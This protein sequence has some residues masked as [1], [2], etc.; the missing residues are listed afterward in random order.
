VHEGVVWR[1]VKR[2]R[3]RPSKV[4]EVDVLID[5][6]SVTGAGVLSPADTFV[7]LGQVVDIRLGN[8]W[9]QVR[10]MRCRATDDPAVRY[11]GVEF[12]DNDNEFSAELSRRLDRYSAVHGEQMRDWD[13]H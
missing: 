4:V 7:K 13:G 10:V 11:W 5:N 12:L 8:H 6:L 2:A 1:V 3:F 9:G